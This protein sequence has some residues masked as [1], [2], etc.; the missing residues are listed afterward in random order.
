MKTRNLW[1]AA[2]AAI[3]GMSSMA[4]AAPFEQ[5]LAVPTAKAKYGPRGMMGDFVALQD[6]ALLMS[7]TQDGSIAAVK[8]SDQGKTWGQPFTLVAKPQSP[9]KGYFCHPSFLRMTNGDIL[10]SY[11]YSTHPTTPYFGDNYYRRSAD[12]GKTW[13]DQF[14]ATPHPGYVIAHND[15]LSRLSTGRILLVA[16]YKAYMPSTSDHSGYVGMTFFSDDDGYSWQASKN[17]VDM[18]PVEVQEADV[19]E[20]KDKSLLMFARTY[21]GHPV[22]ASSKDGGNTWSKGEFIKELQM[23]HASF[24][25]VRRIPSTGDL[26][27][28]WGSEAKR[29]AEGG[30]PRRCA[31]TCAIS[32]DEGKTFIHQRNIAQDPEDDF[33]YQ[34]LEFVGNDL[35]LLGY[36]AREGLRVAR[37]GI[38][39]F[40]EK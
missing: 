28:I 20:L 38:D 25:T 27:F 32:Q 18:H 39:W 30:P 11:I 7:F 14:V 15:R 22:R 24:P 8:S 1:A 35:A 19:V 12:D 10:L 36:H 33:G 16:E 26:L 2:L 17:T 23:Q 37:I 9:G 34:C 31:L 29:P 4:S 5:T 13:T 40:Y 3:L 6:G 21:S